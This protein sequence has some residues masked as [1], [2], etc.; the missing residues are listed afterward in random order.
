GFFHYAMQPPEGDVMWGKM[1]YR[2]ITP[3]DRI[4]FINS[5]SDETG[6][7]T[8]HPLAPSWPLQLLSTF[9]FEDLAAGKT[10]FTVRWS[11]YEATADEHATFAAE[12]SRV[13]MTDGWTGT[14]NRLD[15]YLAGAKEKA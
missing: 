12:P 10:K 4:V 2:E 9:A 14:L 7:V 6:G 8:R 11:P 3:Q 13:S 1:A 15:A 5:F